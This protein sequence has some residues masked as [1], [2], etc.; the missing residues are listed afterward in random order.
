LMQIICFSMC[1]LTLA[2]EFFNQTALERSFK[3]V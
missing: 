3:G 1:T 2:D